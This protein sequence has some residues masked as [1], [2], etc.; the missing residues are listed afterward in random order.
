MYFT[1]FHYCVDLPQ[2][3]TSV[4]QEGSK[5][6]LLLSLRQRNKHKLLAKVI[7]VKQRLLLKRLFVLSRVKN[8][9][10][11]SALEMFAVSISES[12]S[13]TELKATA[14]ERQE[15]TTQGAGSIFDLMLISK[16]TGNIY[17]TPG[18]YYSSPVRLDS[19]C[20]TLQCFVSHNHSTTD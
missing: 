20:Q 1:Q 8:Q 19:L 3:K 14:T 17:R 4:P 11:S 12:F 18:Q 2:I 16:A 13:N 6:L 7:V 10:V 15:E 5:T 9:K